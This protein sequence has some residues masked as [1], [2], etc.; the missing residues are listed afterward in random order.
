MNYL[1][2]RVMNGNKG[3]TRNTLTGGRITYPTSEQLLPFK[4]YNVPW[5]RHQMTI[6]ITNIF[7]L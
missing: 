4:I 1:H 5:T 7:L 6:S 2:T 3:H